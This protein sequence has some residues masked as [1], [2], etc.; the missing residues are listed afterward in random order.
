MI[1]ITTPREVIRWSPLR[2]DFP[3]NELIEPINRFELIFFRDCL[4]TFHNELKDK[5]NDNTYVCYEKGTSYE[6]NDI[7]LYSGILYTSLVAANTSIPK[8]GLN[9]KETEKFSDTELENIWNTCLKYLIGHNV[10]LRVITFTTH[11][12]GSKGLVKFTEDESNITGAG[13]K[14][15]IEYKRELNFSINEYQMIFN[16]IVKNSNSNIFALCKGGCGNE[17]SLN[18]VINKNRRI[19]ING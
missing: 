9:W 5:L 4:E 16:D 1:A 14:E 11:Q 17:S 7:V 2:N 3:E 8:I 19:M 18:K 6:F 15:L 12:A 13:N 10:A